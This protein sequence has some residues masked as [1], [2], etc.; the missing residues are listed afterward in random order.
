MRGIESPTPGDGRCIP[1]A[2]AAGV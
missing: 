2:G 1:M